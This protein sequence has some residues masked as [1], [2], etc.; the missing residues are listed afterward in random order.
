MSVKKTLFAGLGALSATLISALP[1]LAD[2]T[3]EDAYLRTATPMAKTG[4]A[5]MVIHN[6]GDADDRLIAASAD[7]ADVTELHTHKDAGDGVMK[8][9]HVEEG[10]VIPAGGMH[11]LK[12]GGD[13]VMLMGLTEML[14]QG[15]L[16]TVTLTFETAGEITLDIP[17]DREPGTGNMGDMNG[18]AG[19]DDMSHGDMNHGD[20]S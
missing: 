13:H 6:D 7:I 14:E 9:I 8:M 19:M 3:I 11:A 1:A 20:G 2:I 10:F 18:A 17:V 15:G 12:R 4:A 5:F 16:V